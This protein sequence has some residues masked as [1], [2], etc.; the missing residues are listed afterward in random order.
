[1]LMECGHWYYQLIAIR[2][3][4]VTLQVFFYSDDLGDLIFLALLQAWDSMIRSCDVSYETRASQRCLVGWGFF[5][6]NALKKGASCYITWFHLNNNKLEVVVSCMILYVLWADNILSWS[7]LGAFMSTHKQEH[8]LIIIINT[9]RNPPAQTTS[10][11]LLSTITT[12]KW[13][14]I[15][16][17]AL[18]LLSKIRF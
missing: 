14:R 9:P 16:T 3:I 5:E 18:L 11:Q 13:W 4:A 2:D 6:S 8:T 10:I 7:L 15:T 12:T 17:H 1:M